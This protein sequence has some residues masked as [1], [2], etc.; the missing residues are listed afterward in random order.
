MVTDQ[1]AATVAEVREVWLA[2]ANRAPGQA[3]RFEGMLE[4]V[5]AEERERIARNIEEA[6]AAPIEDTYDRGADYGMKL[7]ARIAREG[8]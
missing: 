1:P 4:S 7:A 5:R 8:A 3:E 2:V 6:N